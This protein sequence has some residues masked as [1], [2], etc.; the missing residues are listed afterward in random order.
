ASAVNVPP[1]VR[2]VEW[3]SEAIEHWRTKSGVR[4]SDQT[5]TSAYQPSFRIFRELIGKDRR[6]LV[7]E[8]GSLE[9]SQLDI[10]LSELS[11]AHMELLHD[12]LRKLPQRQGKRQDGLE[13]LT[14]LRLA[15]ERRWPVQSPGNVAKKLSHIHP[16]VRYASAK[17]WIEHS[18]ALELDLQL[19][20]AERRAS[21]AESKTPKLGAI[22]LST[23]EL[24]HTY[25]S[26]AYRE[27]ALQIDWK[28]WIDPLRLYTGARVSE[29]SQLYTND[30]VEVDG[31]PC[32]SFVNDI[33]TDD[34]E[35]SDT[36]GF[37]SKAQTL[38]EYRRLKN[39]ASRRIIPIHPKLIELGFLEWVRN[40][41]QIVGREP[42]LLFFGLTWEPK[43]GYGR[44][45]SQHTLELLK[46][47][48]VW[49]KRRKVG[50]SLRANCAQELQR[51]GMP[52]DLIQRYLG[53]S[54]G[55]ELETSYMEG[56]QGPAYPARHALNYLQQMDF[57]V[58][59]PPYAQ[60]RQLQVEHA[61]TQQLARKNSAARKHAA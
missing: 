55:T 8:D 37:M 57:G 52:M 9:P 50:H 1:A 59:F 47:A 14:L 23:E 17:G 16:F 44:K 3:L 42:G 38:E 22:A 61:R 18:V 35:E 49:Q 36:G 28:Y 21:Q 60:F 11:R 7:R 45:P 32:F 46:A 10:R 4:F 15:K 13:A 58:Q 48:G 31:V 12:L 19:K 25:E 39:R 56:E 54:T 20:A 30:I 53:H 40:R 2:S 6:D 29:I 27:G 5:W 33:L 24:R 43:S 26:E 51:V 41:R 34:D